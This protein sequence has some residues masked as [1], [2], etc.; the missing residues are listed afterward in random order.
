MLPEQTLR[1]GTAQNNET[2]AQKVPNCKPAFC[3]IFFM[4]PAELISWTGTLVPQC[5]AKKPFLAKRL[6]P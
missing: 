1:A 6:L 5:A 3:Q 2:L 4:K